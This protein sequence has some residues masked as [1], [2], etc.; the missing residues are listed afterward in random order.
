MSLSNGSGPPPSSWLAFE[1]GVLRRLRFRS[2]ALPFTGEPYLGLYLKRWGVRVAANDIAEWAHI[3]ST[4]FIENNAEQLSESDVEILLKDAYVPREK[5][6]NPSLTKWFNDTDACWFDNL[7]H[8]ALSF[9]SPTRRAL[10]L[11]LGMMVG[12]YALSFGEET[13]HLRGPLSLPGAFRRVWQIQPSLVNNSQRNKS[14]NREAKQ[15]VAEQHDTEMLF[16]R[17]PRPRSRHERRRTALSS[18]REEWLLGGD[19][20]W[21][22]AEKALAGRLGA[23]V[24]TKQQYLSFVEDLLQTAAHISKWA[25]AHTENGFISTNDLVETVNRVRRVDSI[26]SKD[27]SEL[28]AARATIITAFG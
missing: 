25:I 12:D 26:Y 11:S 28:T 9:D 15:F 5:L 19:D 17:L 23:P 10:A 6:N 1:L 27:F 8:H 18:W 7:R 2:A 22:D 20:F 13:R 16:I 21:D 14:E 3:K 4:A 24:E